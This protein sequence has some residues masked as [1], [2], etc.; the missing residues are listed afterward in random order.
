MHMEKTFRERNLTT[1]A[2]V[3]LVATVA[4]IM[5]SFQLGNLPL[6]AGSTYTAVFAEAG[7]LK[8]GDPVQVAGV[9]V[10]KVK[11]VTLD[12]AT[13][14]VEFNAKD[15]D[16]GSE[17]RARIK[18][19]T[20]LGARYV[21]LYPAGGGELSSSEIPLA[22]TVAPYNL[23]DSL[24][25]VAAH[26]EKLD[27][28]SI[29]RAM[30]SF[31]QTF[32]DTSDELG[33]AFEGV[34]ALSRTISSR[35]A[36]LRELFKRAESVTGTFRERTDQIS[37]LIRDGNLILAELNARRAVIGR[38]IRA[39]Q[40]LAD[41]ASNIVIDNRRDLNPAL[42]ELNSLLA[43]LNKNEENITVAIQRASSFITGL[44]EGVAHG[45]W[46]TG[47]LDLATGQAGLPFDGFAAKIPGATR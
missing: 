21:A 39:S 34:T 20:L 23:S 41:A 31:S 4:A 7:G 27:M 10:G 42:V 1:L 14:R 13:V 36:E 45:P 46:F 16:L 15:V 22:R 2:L 30:S 35:D 19:G 28:P 38:L 5:G 24:S 40:G 9:T 25:E 8:Q 17:T 12:K 29:A 44:G 33:P 18:T 6:I 11:S 26:T 37:A 43:L 3:T 32:R 47:H